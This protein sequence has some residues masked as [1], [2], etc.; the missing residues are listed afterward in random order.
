MGTVEIE[1]FD[2]GKDINCSFPKTIGQLA[3]WKKPEKL[4]SI[5]TFVWSNGGAP[6]LTKLILD[7]RS[8]WKVK[9]R[10]WKLFQTIHNVKIRFISGLRSFI[11]I[12]IKGNRFVLYIVCYINHKLNYSTFYASL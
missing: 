9:N 3:D 11:D 6:I 12:W 8:I 7:P 2:C 1:R 5:H 4:I 10:R